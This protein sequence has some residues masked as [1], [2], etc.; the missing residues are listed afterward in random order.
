MRV[1]GCTIGPP[2][3]P[4]QCIGCGA[5]YGGPPPVQQPGYY[6]PNPITVDDVRRIVREE[7]ERHRRGSSES[8]PTGSLFT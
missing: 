8:A 5:S 2:P 7:L 6:T 1:C 3:W 4:Q